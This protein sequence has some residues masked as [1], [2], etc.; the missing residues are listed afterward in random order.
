MAIL[1]KGDRVRVIKD[2]RYNGI[3]Y[4]IGTEMIIEKVSNNVISG[5]IAGK[6]V[7][8]W[9]ENCELIQ[10]YQPITPKVGQKY[11]V[12]KDTPSAYNFKKGEILTCVGDR[13]ACYRWKCEDTNYCSYMN[14]KGGLNAPLEEY[15]ELV[16][17]V[18]PV[19]TEVTLDDVC[20]K[21][22][23]ISPIDLYQKMIRD[24]HH[25]WK[26]FD[27]IETINKPNLKTKMTN[28]IKKLTQSADDKVLEQAGF[29]DSC[30]ELTGTGSD[31]LESLIFAEKKAELVKLAQEMI[32]ESKK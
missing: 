24:S 16:E 4:P 25:N 32:D 6:K 31:A 9:E 8:F 5:T 23:K 21:Y 30:G 14:P 15:L 17:D 29:M 1:K 11:R 10:G 12:L 26:G 28:F 3:D 22:G 2:E 13:K 19:D 20:T 18:L 7:V 27:V